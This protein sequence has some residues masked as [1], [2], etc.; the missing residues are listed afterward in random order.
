M[1]K[2][3]GK[4]IKVFHII[5]KLEL[6]GAQRVTLQTLS[7]LNRELFSPGLITSSQGMLLKEALQINDLQV[8]LLPSLVREISPL[9]DL[10][11][12]LKIWKILRSEKVD[13]VHTHCSKAGVVGRWAAYLAGVPIRIHAVHGFA[14]SDF[15]PRWWRLLYIFIE[16]LTSK[17]T[18]HFFLDSRANAEQGR[19]HR[20]FRRDNYSQVTPGIPLT[21]FI[22]AEVNIAKERERMGISQGE[23]VVGMIAC[24]KPQKAPLD[25]I[26]LAG[27]VVERL[28]KTRFLLVGDGELRGDVEKLIGQLGL[29]SRVIL[30]GWRW[31]IPQIIAL[32]QVVVLTSLWEGM[33]TVLPM[34]HAM[35]KPVVATR[36]DGSAEVVRNGEN[37]FL[38]PPRNPEEMADKVI[39]LLQHPAVA[40][41]MGERGYQA[42]GKYDYPLMVNRLEELYHQLI[43]SSKLYRT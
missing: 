15:L 36:V 32:C 39:Y 20:L 10:I 40:R 38:V 31:D 27:R 11:A 6:G 23:K 16:K 28:P 12:L 13:I 35:R 34:A 43:S 21:Q 5:T 1:N 3:S 2:G 8:F 26:R 9:N 17:I 30:A 25:F 24:F 29:E 14:F 37:G 42:V 4:K 41:Q 7:S 33:P 19:R 18:T 22:E